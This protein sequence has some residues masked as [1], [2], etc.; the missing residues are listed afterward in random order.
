MTA[1]AHSRDLV[2]LRSKEAS[3]STV[4]SI[5]SGMTMGSDLVWVISSTV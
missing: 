5:M 2:P 4:T 3:A 1:S